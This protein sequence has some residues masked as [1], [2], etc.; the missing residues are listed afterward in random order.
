MPEVWRG[1]KIKMEEAINTKEMNIHEKIQAVSIEVMNIEKDMTVGEGRF[2][3]KAVSDN[4]VT[5]AV[6]RAERKYRINSI[7]V[8]QEIIDTQIVK[9]IRSKGNEGTDY[10]DTIKTT[11]E[12]TDLDKPEDKVYVESCGRGL[13]SGDKGLGKAMT[14]ARKYALLNAY[15]I[16]T[17]ED[18]DG[19]R[20]EDTKQASEDKTEVFVKNY[21]MQ[22]LSYTQELMKYYGV[23]SFEDFNKK[24]VESIYANIQKKLR[25]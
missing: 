8:K 14:Y 21:L 3:Y 20:S 12:I 7:P 17:G 25:K 9:V 22:N 10:V 4:V 15:K 11:I 24:Q 13:D 5:L 6:K 23:E 18:P 1:I 19:D 16:A 2:S